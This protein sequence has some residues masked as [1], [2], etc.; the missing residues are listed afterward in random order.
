MILYLPQGIN[1]RDSSF[2]RWRLF[3]PAFKPLHWDIRF[4]F[5]GVVKLPGGRDTIEAKGAGS[6]FTGCIGIVWENTRLR[7]SDLSSLL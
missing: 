3:W 4:I 5:P 7:H 6:F 2:P 1:P